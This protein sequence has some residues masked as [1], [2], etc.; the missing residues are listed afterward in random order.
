MATIVNMHDAK[1]SLSRLVKRAAS[2]EGILIAKNG[3]PV[4]RLTRLSSRKSTTRIG[5]FAGKLHMPDDFDSILA[6][7][8]RICD[9]PDPARHQCTYLGPQR[10]PFANPAHEVGDHL[11]WRRCAPG[12]RKRVLPT[13]IPE[14][15]ALRAA[16]SEEILIA[17]NGKPVARL[18]RLSSRK[19]TTPIG[20]FAGKLHMADDFDSIPA[21][22]GP[23]L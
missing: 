9:T 19:P 3:K 23:Y 18:T 7:S 5:A 13:H 16:S 15:L 10:R 11:P 14:P 22:F 2:G 1:S 17:K 21:E 8:G 4:A 6:E 12:R 20:A